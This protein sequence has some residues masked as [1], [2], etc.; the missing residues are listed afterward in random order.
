MRQF[1]R[2]FFV[3]ATLSVS[4]GPVWAQSLMSTAGVGCG[5]VNWAGPDG[6]AGTIVVRSCS[7]GYSS[8]VVQLVRVDSA[9]NPLQAVYLNSG[10]GIDGG[11][12]GAVDVARDEASGDI[13][14]ATFDSM[15]N[16]PGN[17]VGYDYRLQRFGAQF[18]FLASFF[19]GEIGQVCPMPNGE[20][21]VAANV[22][23]TVRISRRDA[24]GALQWTATI[25][26]PQEEQLSGLSV[27]PNGQ[28]L[29]CGSTFGSIAGPSSGGWDGWMARVDATSGSIIWQSQFGSASNDF[30]SQMC[31]DAAG[32]VYVCGHTAGSLAGPGM[33]GAD[34]WVSRLSAQGSTLWMR[35]AGTVAN[36]IPASI[37]LDGFGGCIVAGSTAGS[38]S[39]VNSGGTDSLLLRYSPDGTRVFLA[40][41]N[42]PGNEQATFVAV[43]PLGQFLVGVSN[44]GAASVERHANSYVRTFCTAGTSVNGCVPQISGTGLPS[45]SSTGTFQANVASV[46]GQRYGTIFYGFYQF[47]TPWAPGSPSVKCIASPI[48]RMGSLASNG[49]AGQCNGVLSLDINSWMAANPTALGG[50]FTPGQTIHMQGWYRDAGAPGQTNLSNAMT[51]VLYD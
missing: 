15:W 47:V 34:I 5:A 12:F 30:V 49:N 36:D 38:F 11:S 42:D 48:V 6:V 35:Q 7:N 40:Q 2:L 4:S 33:G 25:D 37:A 23:G 19:I 20:F 10:N 41:S 17:M 8:G 14:I 51:I 28:L 1:A 29:L 26:S 24:T 32:G 43:D 27:L 44:D 9:G 31:V 39:G 22:A 16:N 13:W 45:A 50:P 18:N 46:P 21:V 3:A